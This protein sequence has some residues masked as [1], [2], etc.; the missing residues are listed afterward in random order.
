MG[1]EELEDHRAAET[2]TVRLQDDGVSAN[3]IP[4]S[5]QTNTGE[6]TYAAFLEVASFAIDAEAGRSRSRESIVGCGVPEGILSQLGRLRQAERPYFLYQAGDGRK[7][8]GYSA[9]PPV[10]RYM[11]PKPEKKTTQDS[12]SK[13][14]A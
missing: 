10:T 14:V 1:P 7:S 4:D 5:M 9:A 12:S 8:G 2:A 3:S 11:T 13:Q 6:L